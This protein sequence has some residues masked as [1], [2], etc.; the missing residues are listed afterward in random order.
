M[1][2]KKNHSS[3]SRSGQ[4]L[5][6]VMVA[7]T[8]LTVSFIGISSLLSQS[9]VLNRA[10][11][12]EATATYL[13]AEGV[14]VAKNLI[15][16]DVYAHIACEQGIG[17]CV[18]VTEW[19]SCFSNRGTT[20]FEIDYTTM[21]CGALSPFVFPGDPLWYHANTHLYNYVGNGGTVTGFTRM[22]RAHVNGDEITVTAEVWWPGF[23]GSP[24]SINLEDHFYNWR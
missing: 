11:S 4:S 13:A 17:P 23:G 1:F 6:E 2:I 16:H 18:P 15:D 12:N 3:P 21:D 7:I 22:M 8:M 9:I 19:G 10:I 5:I 24:G 20:D 14:E